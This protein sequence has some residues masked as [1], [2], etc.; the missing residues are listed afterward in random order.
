VVA[1]YIVLRYNAMVKWTGAHMTKRKAAMAAPDYR[2]L[3]EFRHALR[4]FLAFSEAA[5]IQAGLTPAQHQA[6]LGIKGMAEQPVS[7]GALADWLNI[8]PHS[9]AGLVDRLVVQRLVAR[10]A[11]PRDRRRVALKLTARADARLAALSAVHRDELRR[12]AGALSLLL[13]AIR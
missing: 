8:K 10:C 5:A 9:C 6:L 3:A 11:D 7:V 1:I 4:Q 12:R 13:A 2:A